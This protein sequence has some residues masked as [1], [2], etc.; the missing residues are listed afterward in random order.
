MVRRAA[1][2]K[3]GETAKAYDH[4]EQEVVLRP[5]IG[6]RAQFVAGKH[7]H[8]AVKVTDDRGNESLVV[9]RFSSAEDA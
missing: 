8:I 4:K 1:R 3:S 2:S 6:M 5:D 7:K 9:K